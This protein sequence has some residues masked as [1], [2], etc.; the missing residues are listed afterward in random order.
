MET[1]FAAQLYDFHRLCLAPDRDRRARRSSALAR[2]TRQWSAALAYDAVRRVEDDDAIYVSGE[3][4]GFPLAALLQL[5]GKTHPRLVVR[6]ETPT[7]GRTAVRRGLYGLHRQHAL[8]RIDTLLC[9]TSAHLQY[10]HGVE[11]VP[12]SKLA[13]VGETVDTA[14]F[15]PSAPEVTDPALEELVTEP[16]I[17]SAGLERRDYATLTEAVRG[18]PLQVVI[19]AGSPWSHTRFDDNGPL[20][21]NV[22]VSSFSPTQMRELYRRAAFVVVPVMPTLRACGMNVVLEAWAMGKA[23][24]ATR[25]MGLLDYIVDGE[26]GLLVPPYDVDTMRAMVSRVLENETLAEKLGA[27]GRQVV[28]SERNLDSYVARVGTYLTEAA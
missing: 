25:T 13:V 11:H 24:V 27:A 21:D 4:V 9:R 26:T 10:L 8:R 23:V 17:V 14:F 22:H 3:D 12:M 2:G 1:A 7:Y 19:G 5:R 20:P 16:F 6:L 18:L 15:S 28:E